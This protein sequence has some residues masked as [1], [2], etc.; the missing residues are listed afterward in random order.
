MKPKY[1]INKSKS[2]KYMYRFIKITD[3]ECYVYNDK[4]WVHYRRLFCP[5]DFISTIREQGNYKRIREEEIALLI[6]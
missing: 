6:N 1:Y 4:E 3:N 5:G 2:N